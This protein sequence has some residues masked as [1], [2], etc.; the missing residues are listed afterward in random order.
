MLLC[1]LALRPLPAAAAPPAPKNSI[2]LPS[3]PGWQLQPVAPAPAAPLLR[4]F[5]LKQRFAFLARNGTASFQLQADLFHDASG[6]FGAYTFRRPA[7]ASSKLGA[8][9]LTKAARA[10]ALI[11]DRWLVRAQAAADFSPSQL[12]YL[13]AWSDRLPNWHQSAD[14]IPTLP[15]Y[16][17][18]RGRIPGSLR[19]CYGPT[20]WSQALP[21]A[22]LKLAGFE[23]GAEVVTAGYW[24]PPH[25]AELAIISY[26]TPQIADARL[27]RFQDAL[28]AARPPIRL[29]RSGSFLLL[30]RG[31]AAHAVALLG[32][33]HDS[34]I[35]TWN[36]R[37]ITTVGEVAELLLGILLLTAGLLLV[38]LVVGV[39]SGW[40]HA[41]LARLFPGRFSYRGRDLIR[42]HLD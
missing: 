4:E 33:V 30:E 38:A 9:Q 19:Y 15:A 13:V 2:H 34:E 32:S 12:A 18:R 23:L 40:V 10:L 25:N 1:G 22:P 31:G 24:Q 20:G 14:L 7:A 41:R 26:P 11:C 6:A 27:H 35:V 21:W 8:C 16:A 29:R 39:L 42:L 36:Q 5:G 37:P 3:L 28:K 17:P